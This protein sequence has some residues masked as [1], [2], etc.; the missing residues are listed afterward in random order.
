MRSLGRGYR[1]RSLKI[2]MYIDVLRLRKQG[3]GYEKIRRDIE[4]IYGER[5]SIATISYWIRGICSP[6]NGRR[7]LFIEFLQPSKELAYIIGVVMGDGFP[8]LSKKKKRYNDVFVMLRAID[9][10]FIE[11]FARCLGVVLGREPPKVRYIKSENRYVISVMDEALFELL[12]GRSINK[13][14]PFVEYCD[15]CKAMFL[16]GFFDSEGSISKD[17]TLKAYNSN[18]ELLEYVKKL[19]TDLGIEATGPHLSTKKEKL[20]K[21]PRT[22]KIYRRRKDVYYIYVRRQSIP[23]FYQKVGF[24]II[25]KKKRLEEFLRRRGLI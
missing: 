5:L 21:S 18:Y 4:K 23:T 14:K 12:Y 8:T 16:R 3:H 22:G 11:E 17:D 10:E 6:Y 19:L 2:K 15:E 1:L 7:I 20:L 13:I 25:R 24:T 9:L